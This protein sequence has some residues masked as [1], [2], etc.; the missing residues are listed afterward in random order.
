MSGDRKPPWRV[1]NTYRH[2]SKSVP[3]EL[4]PAELDRVFAHE[5]ANADRRGLLVGRFIGEKPPAGMLL[6]LRLAV[7]LKPAPA[8]DM[9]QGQ[10]S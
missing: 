6:P 7:R 2:L 4:A 9:N 8:Q 10:V 5:A 3:R 1:S